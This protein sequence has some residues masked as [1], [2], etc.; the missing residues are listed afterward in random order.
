[1]SCAVDELAMSH[2]TVAMAV[3]AGLYIRRGTPYVIG[4][5][6]ANKVSH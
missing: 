3:T 4:R 2:T 6:V 5:L 1:M